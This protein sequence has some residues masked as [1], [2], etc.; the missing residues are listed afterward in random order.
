G[1]FGLKFLRVD[2]AP[3][4]SINSAVVANIAG[5]VHIGTMTD[6]TRTY[7]YNGRIAELIIYDR[8]LTMS[9]VQQVEC[10]LMSKWKGSTACFSGLTVQKSSSLWSGNTQAQFNLPQNALIYAIQVTKSPGIPLT[11]NSVFIHDQLPANAEF[12]NGDPD[13]AGPLT[14]PVSFTNAG[15]GL[16]WNYASDVRYSNNATAPASLADCTYTPA[17]G[18]DPN[19]RYICARPQGTFSGSNTSFTLSYRTRIK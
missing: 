18:Y 1:A 15:S 12:Y 16:S 17:A 3:F 6:A 9:E 7:N 8:A 19:V 2:G 13:G 4:Q 10:Y 14:D 5:G 11:S